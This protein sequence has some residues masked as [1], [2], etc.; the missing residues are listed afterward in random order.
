MTIST[1]PNLLKELSGDKIIFPTQV[2]I[3]LGKTKYGSPST[4]IT[5]PIT[6]K[7]NSIGF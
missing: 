5:I 6:H 4:I 2:F 7:K 1:R 3:L